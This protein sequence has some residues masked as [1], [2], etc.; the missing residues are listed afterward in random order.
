MSNLFRTPKVPEPPAP[1]EPP[2]D[3]SDADA[4][5]A[6]AQER[7]RQAAARGRSSTILGGS[8]GGGQVGRKTLLGQ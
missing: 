6:A 2:V 8:T 4:A 3:R 7:R 5:A 1:V